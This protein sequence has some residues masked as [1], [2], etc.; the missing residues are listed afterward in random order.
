[1]ARVRFAWIIPVAF[2]VA[3]VALVAASAFQRDRMVDDF[4]RSFENH[5]ESVVALVQEG[6]RQATEATNLV[7]AQASSQLELAARHVLATGHVQPGE[8]M[9]L[10]V[11]VDVAEGNLHLEPLWKNVP[12]IQRSDLLAM[13]LE[14]EEGELVDGSV[15]MELNLYCAFFDEGNEDAVETRLVI[16]RD[17]QELRELKRQVGIGP[18]LRHVTHG[19]VSFAVLQNDQGVLASASSPSQLSPWESDPFLAQARDGNTLAYR[20]TVMEERTYLEGVGPFTLPDASRAVLRVGVDA[21]P[22]LAVEQHA[23]HRHAVLVLV[24]V[25]VVLASFLVTSWM[26]RMDKRRDESER[27]MAARERESDHWRTIGEMAATVAHEVRNPLNTV[28]MAAQRMEQEFT[29][30]DQDRA[31][32]LE[33]LSILK[34]EADRVGRVVTEFLE[35]GRPLVLEWE[36]IAAA[37]LVEEAL[38]SLRFRAIQEGKQLELHNR[39]SHTVRVD[40]RRFTQVMRNVI[41]NAV[42]AIPEGGRV[43]I[44]VTCDLDSMNVLVE[45]NGP[46]M[47]AETLERVQRPFV[48]TKA[49]GTGLGLPLARRLVEAHGG[50]LSLLSQPG[51]GTVVSLFIPAPD[52]RKHRG[53]A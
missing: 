10:R 35:L 31:D 8:D 22:M 40:R 25:L 3:G 38:A 46:G 13:V 20:T 28:L 50:S 12:L 9:G 48:T 21:E 5:V 33:L 19:G 18:L 7:Y 1:M 51:R 11:V 43:A 26:V 39:C 23:N 24:V 14:A 32:Y 49:R 29:V 41:D 16:C 52:G 17:A 53:Q 30:P 47:D 45:D 4:R 6:A 42:D 2:L 36:E 27:A 15:P 44:S 34:A 37:D